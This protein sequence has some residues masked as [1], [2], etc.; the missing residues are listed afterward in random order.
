MAGPGHMTPLK[1][2]D[3]LASL[4]GGGATVVLHSGCA[5]PIGLSRELARNAAAFHGARVYSMMP[6]GAA[7][8]AGEAAAE[9]LEL[10]NFFPGKGLRAAVN[11]GRARLHR[12]PMSQIPALFSKRKLRAD[13]L[14]LHLSPPDEAGNM[15]FGNSL[16]YM[17]AVLDQDPVVI[18]EID[19]S[20]P[21]TCGDTLIRA[22]QVDYVFEAETG[23]AGPEQM[24][25]ATPDETDRRIADNVAGLVSNGAVIQTGIGAI[26]DLV[27]P[28]LAHLS[29]LGIHTGIMTDAI[30]PLLQ[31]G[32]VANRPCVTTMSAGTQKFYDFL[33][34]NREIEFHPCSVTHDART[35]AGTRGL[36]AINSALGIDLSGNVNAETASGRV[37]AAPGGFPDFAR[38]ASAAAGGIS[39]VA[40]RAT[41]K[42]GE[43]S[44]I[45]TAL[46]DGAP[47][48][49]A[50]DH[51]DYVVT[52]HGVAHIRGLGPAARSKALA[53][54]AAP[55]FRDD[56]KRG[57]HPLRTLAVEQQE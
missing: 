25:P 32:A 10:H 11:S 28:R 39:I 40:L 48:T 29:G 12:T 22:D 47:V 6:M 24:H 53:G 27:L 38:G 30:M 16:D 36:C 5:E 8:Y 7:P 33:H 43:S 52:E 55:G 2:L 46:A 9:H 56:L 45:T 13:V 23:P 17:P 15:S 49:V 34:R 18:A 37:I 21:R 20:M 50:A 1:G 41:A 51:I 19:P 3:Q 54:I 44:N 4:F 14:M 35:L 57:A 31:S 42:D 26:P